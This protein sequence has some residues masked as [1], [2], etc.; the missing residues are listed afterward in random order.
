MNDALLSS[1]NMRWCT[2]PDFGDYFVPT[3]QEME[4]GDWSPV[5]YAWKL[6]NVKILP[7]PIPM[8]GKQSLWN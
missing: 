7:E 6:Q 8:E 1:K 2:P 3:E 4:L 5:R